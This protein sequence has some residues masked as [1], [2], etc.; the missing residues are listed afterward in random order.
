MLVYNDVKRQFVLDVIN[1]SIADKIL[2]A[3]KANYLNAGHDREYQSWQ[4]SMQFMRNIVDNPAIDDDVQI[5][6]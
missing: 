4:N 3:I 6:I 1:N 2:D 5:C